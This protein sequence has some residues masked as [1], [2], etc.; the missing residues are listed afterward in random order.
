[1]TS[2]DAKCLHST[3]SRREMCKPSI[4][5]MI[6]HKLS[7]GAASMINGKNVNVM[8]EFGIDVF[9]FCLLFNTCIFQEKLKR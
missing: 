3:S 1:M 4:S 9:A 5:N 8:L 7:Q 6:Y 2:P